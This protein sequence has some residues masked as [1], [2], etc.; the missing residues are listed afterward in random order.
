MKLDQTKQRMDGA[1]AQSRLRA[2]RQTAIR[3]DRTVVWFYLIG[4][5]PVLI[6]VGAAVTEQSRPN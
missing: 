3:L 6:K 2:T 4:E 1:R 5:S